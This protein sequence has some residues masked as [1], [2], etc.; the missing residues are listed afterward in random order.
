MAQPNQ[1]VELPKLPKSPQPPLPELVI[2]DERGDLY[3]HVGTPPVP[4]RVCSRSLA[5]A[6][7]VFAKMLYGAWKESR[8]QIADKKTETGSATEGEASEGEAAEKKKAKDWIIELPEDGIE[9]VKPLR[10]GAVQSGNQQA[11]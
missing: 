4:L 8:P 9:E 7:P 10:K 1:L 5:R 6:C 3:L 11:S 2:F